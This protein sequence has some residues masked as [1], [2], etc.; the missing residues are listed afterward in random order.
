MS[1]E[2]YVKIDGVSLNREWVSK[3]TKNQFINH[4][5]VS[6]LFYRIKEKDR[7]SALTV[8][9]ETITGKKSKS[10]SSTAPAPVVESKE[11]SPAI[12]PEKIVSE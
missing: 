8:I 2:K 12:D 1:A 4:P 9:Y 3:M 5:Q 7:S 11:E 6:D 10:S